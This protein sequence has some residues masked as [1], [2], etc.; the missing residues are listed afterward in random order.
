MAKA[1]RGFAILKER[2]P[3]RMKAIA[4]AGGQKSRRGPKS[5]GDNS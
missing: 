3:A 4:A 2:D 5:S 1:K